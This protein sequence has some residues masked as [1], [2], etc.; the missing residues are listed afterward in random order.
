MKKLILLFCILLNG[1]YSTAQINIFP[2]NNADIWYSYREEGMVGNYKGYTHSWHSG[3]TLINGEN[4]FKFTGQQQY[5][6]SFL[7]G[8]N[9][10]ITQLSNIQNLGHQYYLKSN[11]TI[12]YW[13]EITH[14]KAFYYFAYPQIGDVWE[15]HLLNL[16]DY[17]S[18]DTAYVK[19]DS[20]R[21]VNINGIASQDIHIIPCKKNGNTGN[22]PPHDTAFFL[23]SQSSRVIN[24]LMGPR[25]WRM[26]FLFFAPNIIIEYSYLHEEDIICYQSDEVPQTSLSTYFPNCYAY[27]Y[28]GDKT[29]QAGKL[30]YYPNPAQS[31]L[32]LVNESNAGAL[33]IQ[34]LSL[35]GQVLKSG[36]R[37]ASQSSIIIPIQDVRAGIYLLKCS[38]E[39]GHV[40]T[41]K[42]IKN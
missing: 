27:I 14:Q 32:N 36:I 33:D 2:H 25:M 23:L 11:D 35:T 16:S 6:Y 10:I 4:W 40:E 12:Y 39:N 15:Y 19:V 41:H 24:T 5:K 28:L 37:V 21:P 18:I 9:Q 3:D 8:P 31:E 1:L 17:V 38:D 20:I 42:I 26:G 13:N 22:I 29:E 7:S 30:S 34:L